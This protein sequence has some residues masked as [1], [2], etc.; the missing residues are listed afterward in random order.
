MLLVK[1]QSTIK[2]IKANFFYWHLYYAIDLLV[3][4]VV[5]SSL[6]YFLNFKI[7]FPKFNTYTISYYTFLFVFS[8]LIRKP[9]LSI[10][11]VD[12]D[13]VYF[14]NILFLIIMLITLS[15]FR[16]KIWV[17]FYYFIHK[18]LNS[19]KHKITNTA[20][21][22]LPLFLLLPV[23]HTSSSVASQFWVNKALGKRNE[24][25]VLELVV[26]KIDMDQP[27]NSGTSRLSAFTSYIGSLHSEALKFD[28]I[29]KKNVYRKMIM[30]EPRFRINESSEISTIF[31]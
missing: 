11:W 2:K 21:A 17:I 19:F 24:A 25:S 29:A 14:Y 16:S 3:I 27:I 12:L 7:Q 8:I 13:E 9:L 22:S 18:T 20:Q 30:S 26:G 15:Y 1:I 5:L 28:Y 23:D 31:E 10:F 4:L 6:L